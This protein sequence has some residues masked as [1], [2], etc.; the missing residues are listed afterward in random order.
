METPNYEFDGSPKIELEYGYSQ[1][2]FEKRKLF[3]KKYDPNSLEKASRNNAS[4]VLYFN[5][6]FEVLYYN[7]NFVLPEMNFEKEIYSQLLMVL[8]DDIEYSGYLEDIKKADDILFKYNT[9]E[10]LI[11][12]PDDFACQYDKVINSSIIDF[13]QFIAE[14]FTERKSYV[15]RYIRIRDLEMSAGERAMQNLFSWLVLMPQLDQIMSIT[16]DL[17][18]SKLLLIDEPDLY[19]HPEWQKMVIKQIIDTI[20]KVETMPVQIVLTSHS[21]IILSDFSSKNVI[22]LYSDSEKN[23]TLVDGDKEH[24]NTFGANVYSLFNDA[25]F[26]ESGVVGEWAKSK[27]YDVYSKFKSS[28]AIYENRDYYL[29]FVDLI[30]DEMIKREMK[31]LLAKRQE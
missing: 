22:Y 31:K 3:F 21:P 25:F 23:R 1:K 8:K 6:L 7:D 30:G 19:S 5:L 27:I 9:K 13:Y 10:N 4:N 18:T 2:Y 29:G 24:K 26:M 14:I 16:R 11:D 20:N 12:N 15:L 28:D 17:P